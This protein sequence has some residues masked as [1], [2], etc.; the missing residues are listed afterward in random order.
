MDKRCR[1][2]YTLIFSTGDGYSNFVEVSSDVHDPAEW[3][4]H[5]ARDHLDTYGTD[6]GGFNVF[7]VNGRR[8]A[9][10]AIREIVEVSE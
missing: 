9:R 1:M 3:A 8:V 10:C 2:Q 6:D 5:A 7:D 4:R